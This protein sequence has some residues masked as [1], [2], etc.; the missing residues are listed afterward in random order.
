MH[1]D[2]QHQYTRQRRLAANANSVAAQDT[3]DEGISDGP[4]LIIATD[5]LAPVAARGDVADGAGSLDAMRAEHG[6]SEDAQGG[7]DKT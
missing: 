6:G 1:P 2:I 5:R 3:A 4:V 7:K